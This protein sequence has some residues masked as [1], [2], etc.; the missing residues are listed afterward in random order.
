MDFLRGGMGLSQLKISH[1][2]SIAKCLVL[3]IT[4]KKILS[5]VARVC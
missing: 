3:A 5:L 4:Y 1:F 2:L